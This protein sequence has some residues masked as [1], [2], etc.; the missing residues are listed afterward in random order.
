MNPVV[1][2][3]HSVSIMTGNKFYGTDNAEYKIK[4]YICQCD[5]FRLLQK[6]FKGI[7]VIQSITMT[8]DGYNCDVYNT[9]Q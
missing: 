4:G 9:G 3:V 6:M 2:T 7:I 1:K 8:L 5:L